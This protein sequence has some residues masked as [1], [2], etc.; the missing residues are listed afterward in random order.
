MSSVKKDAYKVALFVG[1]LGCDGS[2]FDPMITKLKSYGYLYVIEYTKMLS[3][4]DFITSKG[5]FYGLNNGSLMK[6]NSLVENY[7]LEIAKIVKMAKDNPNKT[8]LVRTQ[9]DLTI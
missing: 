1:G 9:L 8:V 5:T 2:F 4:N 6:S 7:N 3:M